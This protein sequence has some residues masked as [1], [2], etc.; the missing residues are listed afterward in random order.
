ML[1]EYEP[2]PPDTQGPPSMEKGGPIPI[3]ETPDNTYS[4]E[5]PVARFMVTYEG[6]PVVQLL[7][8]DRRQSE[9]VLLSRGAIRVSIPLSAWYSAYAWV[10]ERL[11]GPEGEPTT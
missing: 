6:G 4:W 3:V 10:A 9:N 11:P 2:G 1:P 8:Q 7:L 5:D